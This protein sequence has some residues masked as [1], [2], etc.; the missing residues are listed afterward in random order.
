MVCNPTKKNGTFRWQLDKKY[1][2]ASS[3]VWIRCAEV[4]TGSP[5]PP[6]ATGFLLGLQDAKAVVGWVD[7][8][9]VG[10]LPRPFDRKAYDLPQWYHT[11]KSKTML[12]TLRFNPAC[13]KPVEGAIN[14]KQ[15]VAILIKLNR[16]ALVPL[17]FDDLQIIKV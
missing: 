2:L 8:D 3:E 4:Y 16:Q 9:E 13:C 12:R 1:N 17:A 11:D 10:G 15:I 7:C 14:L 5:I 6:N